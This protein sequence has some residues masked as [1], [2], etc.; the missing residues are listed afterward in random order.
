M[1]ILKQSQLSQL[2]GFVQGLG[3]LPVQLLQNDQIIRLDFS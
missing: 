1:D 3:A 2:L